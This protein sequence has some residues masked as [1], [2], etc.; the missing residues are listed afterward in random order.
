VIRY[1]PLSAADLWARIEAHDGGWRARSAAQ[2]ARVCAAGAFRKDPALWG[3]VK[4]VFMRLQ[5]FKCVYCERPIGASLLNSVEHDVEHFR[6]KS[7]IKAWPP[8]SRE[9]GAALAYPF[10]TGGAGPT[11]YYWLAFDPL[12]YA[13]SCKTC[14]TIL[15]SNFFPIRGQRGL[16]LQDVPTLNA[17]EE[18]LL[19]FPIGDHGDEPSDYLTFEGIMAQPAH[20]SGPL[21]ERARVT[22]DFFRLNTRPELW[23]ERFRAI[24][25]LWMAIE[26]IN[27]HPDAARRA[28]AEQTLNETVSDGAPQAACARAFLDLARRDTPKAW[29]IHQAARAYLTRIPR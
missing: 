17:T 10:S 14:N 15:K 3:D 2:T 12:N 5:F 1:G 29:E 8:A 16:A 9:A 4:A 20:T 21:H 18:P 19:L 27:I 23:A 28:S 24:D 22:I 13:S 26:M 6:P 7:S 11:G 25:T